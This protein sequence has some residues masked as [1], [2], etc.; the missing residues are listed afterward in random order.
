MKTIEL[1]TFNKL[2]IVKK[3]LREGF[4][5]EFGVYLDGGKAGDILMPQKYIP[6]G[7]NIG[8]EVEV[9][10]YLDHDE[11]PIAT[12]EK[13][14]ATVNSFAY[15][16]CSWVNEYGAFLSW[17]VTKDLF[18][19]FREQKRR[20]EIGNSYIIFMYIDKETYRLVASAKVEHFLS[21]EFPTYKHGEEVDLLIWQKTDLGFKVIVDNKYAGLIYE[22]QVFKRI[23]TGDKLKGYIANVRTDG[24]IDCTL[25]PIGQQY[26]ISFAERLLEYLKAHNGECNL[27]DKSNAEDIKYQFQVSKKVYKK[28]I[29]DLYKKHLIIVEPTKIKLVKNV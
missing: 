8:D 14:L 11:R 4:G 20:M 5:E 1:G 2:T 23:H 28:A 15:L 13:P 21:K 25:Q 24:K 9:L 6:Q 3:A 22:D 18:C 12:T 27:G 16:S 19:P 29:G 10:V 26:A 7:A 17:G